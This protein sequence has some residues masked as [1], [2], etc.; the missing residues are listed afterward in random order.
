M[1]FS[2]SE[3]PALL[4]GAQPLCKK[5]PTRGGHALTVQ[6]Q[7]SLQPGQ[8]VTVLEERIKLIRK[9]NCDIADWLGVCGYPQR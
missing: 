5:P 3:Y 7:G 6:I 1:D 9:I 2:R 4:V 8:A